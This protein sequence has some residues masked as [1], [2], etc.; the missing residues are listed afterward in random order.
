MKKIVFGTGFSALT[1]FL[2][3]FCSLVAWGQED[4][5]YF[6]DFEDAPLHANDHDR[7]RGLIALNAGVGTLNSLTGKALIQAYDGS[8]VSYKWSTRFELTQPARKIRLE[9]TTTDR[10][11]EDWSRIELTS[12]GQ[13]H[14]LFVQPVHTD[15]MTV[16][17]YEAPEGS[18][19]NQ[20]H[21][22]VRDYKGEDSMPAGA[23]RAEIIDNIEV[24]FTAD[25][26][27]AAQE[28]FRYSFDFE[29]APLGADDFYQTFFTT[30]NMGVQETRLGGKALI[31]HGNGSSSS[32]S[33]YSKIYFA[34]PVR[35][36]KLDFYSDIDNLRDTARIYFMRNEQVIHSLDTWSIRVAPTRFFYEAEEG[37]E[38]D[39]I[40]IA[41]ADY[42][43]CTDGSPA[44]DHRAELIDNMEVFY[45]IDPLM[46]T[47][48]AQVDLDIDVEVN[49]GVYHTENPIVTFSGTISNRDLAPNAIQEGPNGDFIM[50]GIVSS[51]E[52]GTYLEHRDIFPLSIEA[53]V[54]EEL[55]EHYRFHGSAALRPGHNDVVFEINDKWGRALFA[56]GT[57][58]RYYSPRIVEFVGTTAL[59][60][61]QSPNRVEFRDNAVS[62]NTQVLNLETANGTMTYEAI[63]EG[64]EVLIDNDL[65][66]R[67]QFVEQQHGNSIG[68]ALTELTEIEG[69]IF[70]LHF[71]D[72]E[73]VRFYKK[74]EDGVTFMPYI[75]KAYADILDSRGE[76]IANSNGTIVP[77]AV[78]ISNP[79]MANN[80]I[81]GRATNWF[82]PFRRVG[83]RSHE[84]TMEIRHNG[85]DSVL[86]LERQGGDLSVNGVDLFAPDDHDHSISQKSPRQSA[87]SMTTATVVEIWENQGPAHWSFIPPKSLPPMTAV[88]QFQCEGELFDA[89]E[90]ADYALGGYEGGEFPEFL[91]INNDYFMSRHEFPDYMFENRDSGPGN[92][93]YE[94]VS[95]RGLVRGARLAHEDNPQ[96]HYTRATGHECDLGELIE[97]AFSAWD[98]DES[99]RLCQSDV[100]MYLQAEP[101]YEWFYTKN[102]TGGIVNGHE[103]LTA[104]EEY[105][106]AVVEGEFYPMAP[107]FTRYNA[108]PIQGDLVHALGR[109]I[110][111]CGHYPFKAEVHPPG[112]LAVMRR[113]EAGDAERGATFAWINAN[114][115]FDGRM[116]E[117]IRIFGPPRPAANARFTHI[118][119]NYASV[120]VDLEKTIVGGSNSSDGHFMEI[121]LDAPYIN[122]NT[123]E[124]T[125]YHY[126]N[127]LTTFSR[128][129]G[130]VWTE[131]NNN[132]HRGPI[133]SHGSAIDP[134][135]FLYPLD[136]NRWFETEIAVFWEDGQDQVSFETGPFPSLYPQSSKNQ[137]TTAAAH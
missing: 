118:N 46:P 88:D 21:I 136:M 25:P 39:Q 62:F 123:E 27:A 65:W 37:L 94:Q 92:Y 31:Q 19:F 120:G 93:L 63:L 97:R 122:P 74:I 20:V 56:Y 45:T 77:R 135:G 26:I 78:P 117:P 90:V 132:S 100:D 124:I 72:F 101:G 6:Y 4:F 73:K 34:Q 98:T 67:V 16:F 17:E 40:A 61:R 42:R 112:V 49:E 24:T 133:T 116:V 130:W 81:N 76:R 7:E 126:P 91:S 53:A 127:A 60:Q 33:N 13:T 84:I 109:G 22:Q 83:R 1:P 52:V 58:A 44:G 137:T 89:E 87:P 55:G 18:T 14:A 71:Q 10:T 107:F 9:Y 70:E 3:L 114:W 105:N 134:I 104:G 80:G 47:E 41:V 5:T 12:N 32:T 111:D 50:A 30:Y 128:E 75:P 43:S 54:S 119:P 96:A 95:L 108:F 115:W 8:T 125:R 64:S 35:K 103:P 51:R 23:Y 2:W 113:G 102:S 36:I 79:E 57:L 106:S 85:D 99:R 129:T 68:R 38:F 59:F 121:R 69:D 82:V 28:G 48:T 11:N 110:V 66:P 29:D 86:Y 131:P 15:Q